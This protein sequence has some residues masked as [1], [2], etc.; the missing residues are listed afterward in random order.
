MIRYGSRAFN[1]VITRSSTNK[2]SLHMIINFNCANGG[3]KNRKA[4]QAS[5]MVFFRGFFFIK[6]KQNLYT[7]TGYD[8]FSEFL[9]SCRIIL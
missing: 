8:N 3:A 4:Q 7:I 2:V 5:L 9:L 6:N 1:Y